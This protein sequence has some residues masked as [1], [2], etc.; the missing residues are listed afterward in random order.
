MQA[1]DVGERESDE[2]KKP[3]RELEV[4]IFVCV[5]EARRQREDV[6]VM[7]TYVRDGAVTVPPVTL[8]AVTEATQ[9]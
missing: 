3:S 5:A 1:G 8:P 6:R 4:P 7:Y 9:T 2:I